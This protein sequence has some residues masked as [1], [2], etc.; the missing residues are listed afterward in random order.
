LLMPI[1]FVLGIAGI[2]GWVILTIL[3]RVCANEATVVPLAALGFRLSRPDA[4][5]ISWIRTFA[6]QIAPIIGAAAYVQL[7]RRHTGIPWSQVAALGQPQILLVAAAIGIVGLLAMAV[8]YSLLGTSALGLAALY[9]A[10]VTFSLAFATGAHWLLES[11]PKGAAA[12]VMGTSD[13]LRTM[14]RSPRLITRLLAVHVCAVILRGAKLWFL[15]AA[16]GVPLGW[17]ELLLLVAITE[18]SLLLNITPGAL[19]VREGAILAG[20]GL[21]H[22][23]AA[24]ASSVAL[25]DRLFMA[26]ITTLLAAPAFAVLRRP[27]VG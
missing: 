11:L 5:W 9:T 21:L 27:K 14:A 4:F 19:G 16:A 13:A 17:A 18:S 20:A 1:G 26:A 22:I 7:I 6:N 15:F 23:P 8:N 25:I 24:T 12:R 3:A 2:A 10:I